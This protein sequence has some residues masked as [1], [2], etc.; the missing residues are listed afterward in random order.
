[1]KICICDDDLEEL[2]RTTN[3]TKEFF[4]KLN[5][6]YEID[7]FDNAKVLINKLDFFYEE[8][9]YDL[10]LL[11]II[12]QIEGIEVAK[13]IKEKDHDAIIIFV[14]SSKDYAV[15]AFSIHANDYI[16]K[17]IKEADFK[18]KMDNILKL[19]QTRIKTT[20]PFKTEY[21]DIMTIEIDSIIYIESTNR[22][23]VLHLDTYEEIYSPVLRTRFHQAIPFD[24]EKH[25]FFQCHSSYVVNLNAI[26]NI[27]KNGFVMNNEDFVP[28]SKQ[29]YQEARRRYI[30]FLTGE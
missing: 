15:D 6:E 30:S 4:N 25:H 7:T 27:T 28:I 10:Y 12:M 22:R 9:F 2:S 8:T 18:D 16:V 5:I 13:K 3:L 20:F 1:M 17:P 26:K 19:M 21:H 11:D 14:T 29:Y 23:M 24:Y